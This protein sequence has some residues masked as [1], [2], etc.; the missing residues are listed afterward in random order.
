ML[1][2]SKVNASRPVAELSVQN[3]D[4]RVDVATVDGQL[5]SKDVTIN[6]QVRMPSGDTVPKQL[7]FSMM[8]AEL[9]I[10]GRPE[11]QAGRW[12][13]TAIKG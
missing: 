1:F 9:N 13:I 10:P 6:A 3:F 4:P 2:R 7:V 12:V 11:P 8:R 5:V